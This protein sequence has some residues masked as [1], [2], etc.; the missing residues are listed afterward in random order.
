MTLAGRLP[1]AEP[2]SIALAPREYSSVDIPAE[3][4]R[5]GMLCWVQG[6]LFRVL[7]VS[8]PFT[9]GLGTTQVHFTGEAVDAPNGNGKPG[10]GY[11]CAN[12]SCADWQGTAHVWV[13]PNPER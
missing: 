8:A 3:D 1:G 7:E 13:G 2:G 5:P 11:N 6:Y 9:N 10:G 4:L 12:Y